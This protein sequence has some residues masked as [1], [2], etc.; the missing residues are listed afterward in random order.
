MEQYISKSDLAAEINNWIQDARR[1]Y[2]MS[3]VQFSLSDRIESLEKLLDNLEVKEEVDLNLIISWF[4]HIAQIADD[5][6]TSN[7]E[8]M[9]D[10]QALIEIKCLAKDSSEL[11][12]KWYQKGE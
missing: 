11:I 5:K 8:R 9:T 1:R 4:D 12:K 10:R 3:K 7:G 2:T 6:L